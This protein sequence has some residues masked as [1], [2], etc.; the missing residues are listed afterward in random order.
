MV[1]G[2]ETDVIEHVW[3]EVL[4]EPLLLVQVPDNAEALGASIMRLREAGV[5]HEIELAAEP[6]GPRR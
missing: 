2:N 6:G 3:C 4:A 5:R 1:S